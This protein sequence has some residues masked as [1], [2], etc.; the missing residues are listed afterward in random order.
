M[1]TTAPAAS[2]VA[3]SEQNLAVGPFGVPHEG[4][5][6]ARRVAHSEQNFAPGAFSV[7][8]FEQITDDLATFPTD[9][10]MKRE[11]TRRRPG[12]RAVRTRSS[13][14]DE[15]GRPVAAALADQ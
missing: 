3:H 10:V 13:G 2:G 8:Q 12:K 15:P 1:A 9:R 7:P 5:V 14:P 6:T 4:Q 11:R